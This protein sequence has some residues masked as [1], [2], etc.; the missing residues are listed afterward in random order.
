VHLVRVQERVAARVADFDSVRFAVRDAC[1]AERQDAALRDGVARLRA[2][3][4]AETPR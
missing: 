3:Y 2:R 1:I 4:T